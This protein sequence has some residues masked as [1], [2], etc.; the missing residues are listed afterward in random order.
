MPT[1][2]EVRTDDDT[3]PQ[4]L[5]AYEEA[6]TTP[7]P[8]TVTIAGETF[9]ARPVRPLGAFTVFCVRVRSSDGVT[10]GAAPLKLLMAYIVEEDHGRLLDVMETVDDLEAFMAADF[11]KALEVLVQRPTSAP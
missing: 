7:A 10:Q 11:A 2:T 1:A 8:L 9:T 4:A 5:A 3:I 6:D